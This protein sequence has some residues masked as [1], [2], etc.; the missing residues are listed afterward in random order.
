MSDLMRLKL[1]VIQFLH[2]VLHVLVANKLHHAR[3]IVKHV[4][5]ADVARLAHVVLQVLPAASRRKTCDVHHH[6]AE[7]SRYEVAV[8][9]TA[10]S[11]QFRTRERH[12]DFYC[13]AR[14]SFSMLQYP[15][16]LQ[17]AIPETETPLVKRSRSFSCFPVLF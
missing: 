12:P 2:R 5:I 16:R 14:G 4:G 6:A 8:T 17:T 3:S 13:R 11:R 10:P 1:G 7:Q 9:K 15:E